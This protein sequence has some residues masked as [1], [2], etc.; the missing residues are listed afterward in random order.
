L[1]AEDPNEV[2]SAVWRSLATI[3]SDRQIFSLFVEM[4]DSVCELSLDRCHAIDRPF[5]RNGQGIADRLFDTK[6]HFVR[7]ES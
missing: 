2:L 6:D 1:I 7:L 4:S 5:F 3:G